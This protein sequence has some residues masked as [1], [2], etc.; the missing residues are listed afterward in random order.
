M[1]IITLKG[2][3]YQK[4][5]KPFPGWY[6]VTI[7]KNDTTGEVSG[8]EKGDHHYLFLMNGH[9][10]GFFRIG[11]DAAPIRLFHTVN[12]TRK[13]RYWATNFVTK[14]NQDRRNR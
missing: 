13:N 10:G 4:S 7:P 3:I 6:S 14:D 5:R 11:G 8:G 2:S 12:K 1:G 9:V